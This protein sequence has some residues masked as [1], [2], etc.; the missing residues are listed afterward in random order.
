MENNQFNRNTMVL[1]EVSYSIIYVIH[2][3][4]INHYHGITLR[5]TVTV[6]WYSDGIRWEYYGTLNM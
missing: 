4:M 3:N 5:V 1:R 6:L 2:G